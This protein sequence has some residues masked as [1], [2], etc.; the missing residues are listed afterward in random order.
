MSTPPYIR[1]TIM[2]IWQLAFTWLRGQVTACSETN[3]PCIVQSYYANAYTTSTIV[4]QTSTSENEC[5]QPSPK[6]CQ[7][8]DRGPQAPESQEDNARRSGMPLLPASMGDIT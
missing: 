5:L 2:V 8:K 7:I 3:E 6:V 4:R 1:T